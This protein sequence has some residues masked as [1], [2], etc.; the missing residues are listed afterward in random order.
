M[1]KKYDNLKIHFFFQKNFALKKKKYPP[2]A[3]SI[4]FFL[5]FFEKWL[6]KYL[7]IMITMITK[8]LG[9]SFGDGDGM[10]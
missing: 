7:I 4:S 5:N 10:T 8:G 1:Y 6:A 2:L 3:P 9:E